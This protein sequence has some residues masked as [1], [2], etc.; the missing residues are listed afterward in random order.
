[1]AERT[2]PTYPQATTSPRHGFAIRDIN[3]G[4]FDINGIGDWSLAGDV[5]T[6]DIFETVKAAED[7]ILENNMDEDECEIVAIVRAVS[8]VVFEREK[9][10][11]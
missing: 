2:K 11:A 1:M 10:G 6:C 7:C 3:G 5:T 8:C 9:G 4:F